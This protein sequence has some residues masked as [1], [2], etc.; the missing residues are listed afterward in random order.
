MQATERKRKSLQIKMLSTTKAMLKEF[1]RNLNEKL[2]DLLDNEEFMWPELAPPEMEGGADS[3][4][5]NHLPSYHITSV[6]PL[7]CSID[8]CGLLLQP[9][10]LT[11][12]CLPANCYSGSSDES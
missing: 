7:T 12:V 11:Q 2:A 9:V 6:D 10:I 3:Q 1:H 4:Q 5:V 8:S